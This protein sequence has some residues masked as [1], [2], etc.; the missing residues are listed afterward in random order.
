GDGT[1]SLLTNIPTRAG[2]D[3]LTTGDFNGDGNLDLGATFNNGNFIKLF[4]GDGRG[5]FPI[6]TNLSGNPASI[7]YILTAD[8]DGD[9]RPDLFKTDDTYRS[10]AVFLN[11]TLPSL[12]IERAGPAT[13]VVW[14]LW[15]GFVLEMATNLAPA[16]LW[17]RPPTN[18]Y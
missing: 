10:G 3:A 2:L 6:A 11:G 16:S 14:P 4:L 13:R 8:F 17:T 18:T 12:Q 9:G 15:D 1:F 7:N 5:Q